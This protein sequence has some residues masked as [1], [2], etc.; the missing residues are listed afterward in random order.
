VDSLIVLLWLPPILVIAYFIKTFN[1]LIVRRNAC[2]N[3]RASIDVNLTRRHDLIPKLVDAV[4][5]YIVHER[6]TLQ[7][8]I[9][10][11][12]IAIGQLGAA[13]SAAAEQQVE[14]SLARL[15][16]RAEDY[17]ELKAE[18]LFGQ[19]MRNLTEAEEQISASRRAFNGQ[20]LRMNNLVE[21]FP[22]LIVASI[23]GFRTLASYSAA[24]SARA[25]PAVALDQ[26]AQGDG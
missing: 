4:R 18:A 5:G 15:V 16:L 19:L 23:L 13:S 8:V 2:K 14:Q 10:A 25:P 21:Q 9:E 11:R 3:A 7:E 22:T 26:A 17:P 20:V 6:T 24:D 12:Q 1:R